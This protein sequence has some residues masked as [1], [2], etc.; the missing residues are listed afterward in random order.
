MIN[1]SPGYV[2]LVLYQFQ[3]CHGPPGEESDSSTNSRVPSAVEL[4]VRTSGLWLLTVYLLYSQY[5]SL[6]GMA[7]HTVPLAPQDVM[8]A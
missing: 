2:W 1:V 6:C 7:I 5:P 3:V 8:Y 4:E